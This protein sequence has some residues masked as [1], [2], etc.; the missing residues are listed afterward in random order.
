M[1]DTSACLWR[2]CISVG[3][4]SVSVLGNSHP[5]DF[6]RDVSLWLFQGV[7][8]SVSPPVWLGW[9]PSEQDYV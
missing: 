3:L 5:P 8:A 2:R 6:D 4:G 1:I 7:R 9:C